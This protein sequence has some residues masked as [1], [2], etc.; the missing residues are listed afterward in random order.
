MPVRYSIFIVVLCAALLGYYIVPLRAEAQNTLLDVRVG[1]HKQ[2]DRVVFEFQNQVTAQVEVK[3]AQTIEVKF[4]D[5]HVPDNFAMPPL[6]HHLTI[7]KRVDAYRV[8]HSDLVFDLTLEHDATPSQLPLTGNP[9]RLAVDLAPRIAQSPAP[10]PEYIPG[11]L[12]IPTK[13]AGE[14]LAT[15][16]FDSAQVHSVLA[17]FYMERGDTVNAREQASIYQQ[18]TGNTLDLTVRPNAKAADSSAHTARAKSVHSFWP[19]KWPKLGIPTSVVLGIIFGGGL[20]GG[21]ALGKLFGGT[22]PP[23]VKEP[24]P[25]KPKKEKKPKK[26]KAEKSLEVEL[27]KDME[28][29][30]HAVAEEPATK[31]VAVE[32]SSADAEHDAKESLM[33]RRVR[34]VLELSQEG[35]TVAA[36]AEELQMGQDEVK[37]ILD[38]NQ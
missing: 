30:E 22:R 4:S 16:E 21:L 27:E 1:T 24:K 38:L 17:Y 31:K 23:K 33:D 2:F 10:K 34:R 32:A 14:D 11:D 26:K 25:P 29:L 28:A 35:R 9:W 15:D 7:L 36:I 13:L 6:P 12:P 37:L 20:L 18:M 19:K 3:D 8:G 5:V